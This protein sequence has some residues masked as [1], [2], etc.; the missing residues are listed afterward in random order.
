MTQ[1]DLRPQCAI[2][3]LKNKVCRNPHGDGPRFCPTLNLKESV[4][5]A[6][7]KQD[8]GNGGIQSRLGSLQSGLHP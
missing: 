6:V 8:I 1:R 4:R 2:C 7:T 5:A 3:T